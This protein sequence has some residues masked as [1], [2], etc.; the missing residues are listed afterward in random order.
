M[1]PLL[2][3]LLIFSC[4]SPINSYAK[5]LSPNPYPTAGGGGVLTPGPPGGGHLGPIP[6][7]HPSQ[8]QPPHRPHPRPGHP[9]PLPPPMPP[10][11]G[12]LPP[13]APPYNPPYN[14]PHQ[15]PHHPP[16]QPPYAP[17]YA[18]PPQY[19]DLCK[20]DYD[21]NYY[22]VSRNGTRF[23]NLTSSLS[24]ALSKKSELINSGVC[25]HDSGELKGQCKVSY[26]GNYYSVSRNNSRLSSLTSSLNSAIQTRDT[27][28][29]NAE[30]SSQTYQPQDLC[31]VDYDGNYYSVSVNGYRFTSLTSSLN[32]AVSS[33]DNLIQNYICQAQ[34]QYSSCRLEYDGNYYSVSI[35]SK[36]VTS[37]TSSMSSAINQQTDLANKGLCAQ[38]MAQ[39]RCSVEYN[40]NYYY[41]ARNGARL[42]SLTS[43]FSSASSVLYQLQSSRNCY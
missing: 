39:D 21:G 18:P 12:H 16:H 29:Q 41:V 27:L 8:P 40:G 25:F 13:P 11:H 7:P 32:S 38:P 14:P 2:T 10:G 3:S 22:Y 36:R 4:I 19:G 26:D 24:S 31:K 15:P 37:L 5:K 35:N 28:Y 34:H 1:K 23:S 20:V 9:S 17:P 43:S 33:R 30:C 6:H 42:S